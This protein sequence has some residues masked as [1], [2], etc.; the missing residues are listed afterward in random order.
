M[1]SRDH[2]RIVNAKKDQGQATSLWCITDWFILF[3]C[4]WATH[5]VNERITLGLYNWRPAWIQYFKTSV[6]INKIQ[7]IG[8][9]ACPVT[10]WKLGYGV[11]MWVRTADGNRGLALDG[12]KGRAIEHKTQEVVRRLDLARSA[13]WKDTCVPPDNCT[14]LF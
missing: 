4:W 10:V 5:G 12:W 11:G 8:Y 13:L 1:T 9:I 7:S 14:V 2:T 3:Y 6:T